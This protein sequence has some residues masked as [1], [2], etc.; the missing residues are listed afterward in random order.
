MKIYNSIYSKSELE[1]LSDFCK[2]K[3][4]LLYV[5]GARLGS[6]LCSKENDIELSDLGKYT[7]AFYID[8]TLTHSP[9]NQI[10]PIISNELIEELQKKYSFYIW[11]KIDENNSAIR[12]VTSWA[13]QQNTKNYINLHKKYA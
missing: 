4:L 5:D 10:F 9:S 7:D 3:N 13:T 1:N 2:K 6:A 8:A 12:L 11:E